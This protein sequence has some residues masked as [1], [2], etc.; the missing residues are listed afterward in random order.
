[1]PKRALGV[2]QTIVAQVDLFQVGQ[3]RREVIETAPIQ[4]VSMQ[5]QFSQSSVMKSGDEAIRPTV[6]TLATQQIVGEI[7]KLQ[8]GKHVQEIGNLIPIA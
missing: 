1:M 2:F 3:V 6:W 7:E 8:T 4:F 5:N